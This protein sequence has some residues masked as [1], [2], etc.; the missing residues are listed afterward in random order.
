M[1]SLGNEVVTPNKVTFL[2]FLEYRNTHLQMYIITQC[3][4]RGNVQKGL[5]VTVDMILGIR[6]TAPEGAAMMRKWLPQ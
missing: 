1:V 5:Y 4:I 6:L 3:V 2:T